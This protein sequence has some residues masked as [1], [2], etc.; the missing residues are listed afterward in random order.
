MLVGAEEGQH[1]QTGHLLGL[2]RGRVAAV[3][4]HHFV[5]QRRVVRWEQFLEAAQALGVSIDLLLLELG[6]QAPRKRVVGQ[7]RRS[8]VLLKCGAL[9]RAVEAALRY[10]VTAA[11]DRSDKSQRDDAANP[12]TATAADA[13]R[14]R[15]RLVRSLR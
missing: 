6:L 15:A 4:R 13:R 7:E 11:D 12:V 9:D 1:M 2:A 10:P 3:E 8:H 5:H 14:A